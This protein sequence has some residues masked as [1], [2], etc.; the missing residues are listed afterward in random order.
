MIRSTAASTFS[1]INEAQ[2][3][4]SPSGLGGKNLHFFPKKSIS[5]FEYRL[6]WCEKR[7]DGFIIDSEVGRENLG[8]RG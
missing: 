3:S 8:R 5:P 6:K 4:F 1:L 7:Y 2:A